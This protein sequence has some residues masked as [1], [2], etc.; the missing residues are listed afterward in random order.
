[1][2]INIFPISLNKKYC[3]EIGKS[4]NLDKESVLD[5]LFWKKLIIF[6]SNH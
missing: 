3:V 6:I 4:L 2:N 1:M 5:D